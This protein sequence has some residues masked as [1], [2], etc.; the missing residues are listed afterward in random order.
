MEKMHK[1]GWT[2][3]GCFDS[4]EDEAALQHAIA[5]YHGCVLVLHVIVW[6]LMGK[7]IY[8]PHGL[9][10]CELVCPDFGH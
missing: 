10:T 4:S 6:V 5:R 8:R 2:K 9:L 1:F 3:P 7:Q